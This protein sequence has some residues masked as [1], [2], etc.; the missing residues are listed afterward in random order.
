[1]ISQATKAQLID[2][3]EAISY[4]P[5]I[6]FKAIVLMEEGKILAAAGYD[7]WTPNAVQ[8]HIWIPERLS[9]LFVRE[10]FRYPFE[11]GNKGLVIG[12]TP[13]DNTRALELNRHVGFREV[14]RIVDGWTLG[15]DMVIQEMR[16]DECRWLSRRDHAKFTSEKYRRSD[17]AGSE[18]TPA[19]DAA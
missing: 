1:M 2:F 11:I 8:M 3:C 16:R 4:T 5:S 12:V 15:T 19:A 9:K 18:S 7:H 13:G 14:Y 6:R 17:A 10:A